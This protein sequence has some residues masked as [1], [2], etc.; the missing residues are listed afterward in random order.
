MLP[1]WSAKAG[2]P[3]DD[4]RGSEG[5]SRGDIY[6]SG[7]LPAEVDEP[8]IADLPRLIADFDRKN[9]GSLRKLIDSINSYQARDSRD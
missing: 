3:G 5:G 4:S 1:T 7:S 9:F 6:L 2:S 8:E